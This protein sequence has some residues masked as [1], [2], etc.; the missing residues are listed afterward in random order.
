MDYREMINRY[1]EYMYYDGR[2][3]T[4]KVEKD[5]AKVVAKNDK[6]ES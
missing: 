1:L 6:E 4:S 5:V 3:Y 2:V